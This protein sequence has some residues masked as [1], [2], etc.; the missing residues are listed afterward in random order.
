MIQFLADNDSRRSERGA[1]L[2]STLLIIL[3]LVGL[4]TSMSAFVVNKY[5]VL[6]IDSDTV[7]LE[8]LTRSGLEA[9]VYRVLTT[10]PEFAVSGA[11]SVHLTTGD[12]VVSFTGETARIN[13]NQAPR[14]WIAAVIT[15]VASPAD[16][17]AVLADALER[18]RVTTGLPGSEAPAG[19][20]R[21]GPLAHPEE[22]R[23]L[24]GMTE[25][26]YARLEP[27]VTIYS[28][29][30]TI[31]P[32][33]A[34]EALLATL[35]GMTEARLRA[36]L[37]LRLRDEAEFRKI[38]DESGEARKLLDFGRGNSIRFR[39]EARL[40][41]GTQRVSEVVAAL[42]PDDS[43]PYRVLYWSDTHVHRSGKISKGAS[44]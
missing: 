3:M 16:N 27:L 44:M 38:L 9:G 2:I 30:A 6:A 42:F 7:M 41:N 17:P 24:P 39:I 31:D 8:A 32:R 25:R 20:G 10:P 43:E 26:L 21:S 23:S 19:S 1:T 12:V 5:T 36:L 40:K 18:R 11:Y 33:I 35:P 4:V 34:P 14:D 29:S 28:P 15:S 22:L 13:L 37:S